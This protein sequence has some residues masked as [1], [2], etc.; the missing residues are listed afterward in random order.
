MHG[1]AHGLYVAECI[2]TDQKAE[3]VALFCAL[4]ASFS[5][6]AVDAAVACA[7]ETEAP[8]QKKKRVKEEQ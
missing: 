7:D 2:K 3:A 5:I 8:K 6:G 1:F 4:P